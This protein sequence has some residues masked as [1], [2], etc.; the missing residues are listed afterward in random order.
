MPPKQRITKEAVLNAAF[1]ILRESGIDAVNSRAVAARL[2]CSTQP[3]FSQ[4]SSID[5]LKQA[6]FSKAKEKY[7]FYIQDALKKELP[8]KESGKAYISFAKSEPNLFKLLFMTKNFDNVSSPTEV[9]EN[10]FRILE[11][12]CKNTGVNKEK[13]SRLYFDMW[14]VV[15]GI[16]SMTVADTITFSDEMINGVLSD[17]YLGALKVLEGE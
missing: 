16:A 1:E 5:D 2:S 3:I 6:L 9:D 12:I 13:A 4:F 10:H 14:I 17:L 8:F 7:N 11:V 15:H